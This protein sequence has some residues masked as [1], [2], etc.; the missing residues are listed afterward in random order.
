MTYEILKLDFNE[1]SNIWV[2]QVRR[3]DG[4]RG[5]VQLS[6]EAFKVVRAN[7][8]GQ[9]MLFAWFGRA[10]YHAEERVAT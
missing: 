3:R 2:I 5:Q 8:M 4:R 10:S 6:P 1:S 7:P 9:F